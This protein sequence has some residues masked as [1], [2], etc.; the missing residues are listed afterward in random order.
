VRFAS[1]LRIFCFATTL[2]IACASARL[3]EPPFVGQPTSALSE[4]PYPPPPAR[5]ET[6]TPDPGRGV[7]VDGEWVWQV[8]RWLWKP[9]RWV[10]PPPDGRWSPWTTVRDANGTLYVAQGTW[11]NAAGVELEEPPAIGGPGLTAQD[12]ETEGDASASSTMRDASAEAD[13]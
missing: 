2:A 7:W 12:L 9:G 13:L 4:V 3:R 11:R 6:V 8:R 5:V 1:G 10:V